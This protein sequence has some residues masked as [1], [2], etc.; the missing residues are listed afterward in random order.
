MQCQAQGLRAK[1]HW[2][3]GDCAAK[4]GTEC[5]AEGRPW[6]YAI[7]YPRSRSPQNAS[8]HSPLFRR[9]SSS[10]RESQACWK[11]DSDCFQL[12]H[13]WSASNCRPFINFLKLGRR[14]AAA[15][16][17]DGGGAAAEDVGGVVNVSSSTEA[18]KGEGEKPRLTKQLT[19]SKMA[20]PCFAASGNA[21]ETPSSMCHCSGQTVQH[22]VPCNSSCSSQVCPEFCVP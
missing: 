16:Q 3:V 9:T 7:D 8:E 12:R 10:G 21:N 20:P 6:A 5:R 18:V 1:C 14:V 4:T 15:A 17:S 2:R 11:N 19:S 22:W 13:T